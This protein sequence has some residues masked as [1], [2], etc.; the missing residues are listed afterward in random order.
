MENKLSTNAAPL[1]THINTMYKVHLREM[2]HYNKVFRPTVGMDIKAAICEL[3]RQVNR[4]FKL[5]NK[6]TALRDADIALEDLRDLLW[7]AYEL[8][9]ISDGQL[10]VWTERIST[11]GKM[12]GGWLKTIKN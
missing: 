12:I 7:S 3:R 9:C 4:A 10:G 5:Y 2:I 11:V 1:R 8:K 6:G